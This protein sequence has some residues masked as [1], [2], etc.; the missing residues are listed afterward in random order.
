[1]TNFTD[2]HRCEGTLPD[3]LY[4]PALTYC[5]ED[6][7][8][9]LWVDNGEYKSQVNYCPYCGYRAKN[10]IRLKEK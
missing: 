5:L 9:R 4:G 6:E 10:Q 3:A 1:M 8:H 7:Y 2:L